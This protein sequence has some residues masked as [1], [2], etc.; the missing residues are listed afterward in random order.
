[1]YLFQKTHTSLMDWWNQWTEG[2]SNVLNKHT[3]FEFESE[4]DDKVKNISVIK[5]NINM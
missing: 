2:K 4:T 1:M 3:K 5:K